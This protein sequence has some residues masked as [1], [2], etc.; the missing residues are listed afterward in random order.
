MDETRKLIT[1]PGA[2]SENIIGIMFD[3]AGRKA[4]EE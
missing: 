2:W 4:M 3:T 1:L